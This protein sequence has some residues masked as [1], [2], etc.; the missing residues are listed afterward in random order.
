[1]AKKIDLSKLSLDELKTLEKDVKAAISDFHE[2]QR[3]EVLKE[4]EAVA[5]KHGLSIDD[6]VGTKGKRRKAKVSPKYRNPDNTSETWSGRG[7]QPAWF[8]AAIEAGKK[9]ESM[10]I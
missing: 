5:Q 1:M 4:M 9:P 3:A 7:R 8:K 10:A 6:V 2:R